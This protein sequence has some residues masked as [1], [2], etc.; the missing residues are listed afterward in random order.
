MTEELKCALYCTANSLLPVA[1]LVWIYAQL[2]FQSVTNAINSLK[3]AR[4]DLPDSA[5]GMNEPKGKDMH[6]YDNKIHA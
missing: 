2:F 1:T 6:V 3:K 5:K 4:V